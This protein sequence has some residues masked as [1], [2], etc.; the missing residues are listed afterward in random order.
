V[1]VLVLGLTYRHGVKEL[2]YS[3]ALPL[4]SRLTELGA[5]VLAYDPLLSE[6][7]IMDLSAM[8]WTWGSRSDARAIITQTS[9]PLWS[10]LDLAI[11]PDLELLVDGRNSLRGLEIPE[12]VGY[13]GVG[14]P[15]ALR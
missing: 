13:Q 11:F 7:E 3:R 5:D 8:P 2:A 14:V 15:A 9:D 4:I 12:R 6:R 1:P 10:E